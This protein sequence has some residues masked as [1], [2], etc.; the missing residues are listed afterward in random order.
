M[1]RI[2]VEDNRYVLVNIFHTTPANQQR[3]IDLWQGRG[4]ASGIAPGLVSLNAHVGLDGT[5]VVA[6]NQWRAKADWAAILSDPR[7][8]D[9]FDEVLAFSTF[10]SIHCEVVAAERN[11]ALSG[12][13]TEIR[14]DGRHVVLEVARVA[15]DR[16]QE[17]LEL[18]TKP[19]EALAAT[20]GYVSHSIHRA[21]DG[22]AVVNYSQ[23]ESQ[24]AYQAFQA[25]Q[26]E[27][28]TQPDAGAV[29]AVERFELRVVYVSE[30]AGQ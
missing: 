17:L 4:P 28:G 21:F 23:W 13:A 30:A 24:A 22:T 2:A 7:R 1:P 6:Y 15:P 5:S 18:V 26:V 8:Q 16:Q 14:Q 11:E 10:E 27:R 25:D 19:N 12:P 3:L 9:R 20:P 29:G